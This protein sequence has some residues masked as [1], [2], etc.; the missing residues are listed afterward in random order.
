VDGEDRRLIARCLAGDQAACTDFVRLHSRV[1]GTV[2]WRAT[3]DAGVVEDLTQE[4]FLRAFRA[5]PLFEGDSKL[6]TWLCTIAHR[7][8]IDHVRKTARLKESSL[9]ESQD[10]Q[11]ALFESRHETAPDPEALVSRDEAERLVHEHLH[12]LPEKYRMPLVYAAIDGLDYATIGAMLNA[13][14]GTVKTLVFRAKQMLKAK[15]A[16]ALSQ[17]SQVGHADRR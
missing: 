11:E 10:E 9:P 12:E 6:S 14:T 17:Q 5:L 16:A 1:V 15:I 2:I 3:G 8:A 4:T 7:I 13:P